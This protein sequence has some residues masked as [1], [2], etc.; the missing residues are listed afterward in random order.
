MCHDLFA[1]CPKHMQLLT[2]ISTTCKSVL[3]WN[4]QGN[5]PMCPEACMNITRAMKALPNARR[6]ACCD[7]GEGPQGMHCKMTKMKLG[8]ACGYS[9]DCNMVCLGML[10]SVFKTL[11]NDYF[12]L[13]V[14]LC[15][16]LG[17]FCTG[18]KC[19]LLH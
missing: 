2:K 12:Y 19:I 10:L 4:G 6:L 15:L 7:C 8:A 11:S 14:N 13:S 16:H 17:E 18:H 5:P 1:R 9:F 3:D